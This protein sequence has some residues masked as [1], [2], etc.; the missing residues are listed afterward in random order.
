MG[1][2]IPADH[3]SGGPAA[4]CALC[5]GKGSYWKGGQGGDYVSCPDCNGA[6]IACP[7]CGAGLGESHKPGC[8]RFDT[9]KPAMRI[10]SLAAHDALKELSQAVGVWPA[11]NSAHEGFA[12]LSEE[13]DELKEHVWTNQKRRDLA[14]MRAEAIQVAAM[15]IRFAV[16]CTTEETGRK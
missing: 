8:T 7:G 5:D 10:Y 16:E 13:Y 14:K 11:F 4:I 3:S 12:V 2:E 9:L 6:R 15:A 1:Y